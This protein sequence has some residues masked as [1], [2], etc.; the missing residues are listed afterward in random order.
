MKTGIHP[1]YVKSKVTCQGCGD[2]WETMSTKPSINVEICANCHPFYTGKQKLVDT[3]G[4]VDR[5]QARRR[6]AEEIQST[7]TAK[8]PR[9]G[10]ST[11]E[12]TLDE[13]ALEAETIS[14]DKTD[15][16]DI[17]PATEIEAPTDTNATEN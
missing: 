7:K 11:E 1:E 14:L 17:N 4:R 5:F 9:K 10:N 16:P 13:A 8:A 6:A 2:A 12:V 3:A 15:A